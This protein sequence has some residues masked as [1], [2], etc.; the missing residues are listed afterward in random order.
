MHY[1]GIYI[2][3]DCKNLFDV[4]ERITKFYDNVHSMTAHFSNN[5]ELVA[6]RILEKQCLPVLFYGLNA[7]CIADK[8]R[9]TVVKLGILVLEKSSM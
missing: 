8:I 1:L 2:K 9:N 5:N 4:C 3:N 6:L 7:I